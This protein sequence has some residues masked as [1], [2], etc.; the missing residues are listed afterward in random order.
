MRLIALLFVALPLAFAACLDA[1]AA[2][3]GLDADSAGGDSVQITVMNPT[4]QGFVDVELS[5]SPPPGAAEVCYALRVTNGAGE[6]YWAMASLCSSRYGDGPNGSVFYVGPCDAEAAENT[7]TAWVLPPEGA[8]LSAWTN[9]CPAPA[10]LDA[11][12][13]ASWTGGCARTWTCEHA[14][15]HF[16]AFEL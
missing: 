1:G 5:I 7:V 11:D 2:D 8:D 16:V 4:K 12:A 15:D 9:P 10:A 6:L 3:A 14:T 13:P